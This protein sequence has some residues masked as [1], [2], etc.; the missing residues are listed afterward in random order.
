MS[1][2]D[3]IRSD[4]WRSIMF[5]DGRSRKARDRIEFLI[6]WSADHADCCACVPCHILNEFVSE[7]P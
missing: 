5:R 7:V 6:R 3:P 2:G 4:D 1:S